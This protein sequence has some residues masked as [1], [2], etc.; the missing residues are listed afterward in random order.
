MMLQDFPEPLCRSARQNATVLVIYWT[1]GTC[2]FHWLKYSG[3][4][5]PL[6]VSR[7]CVAPFS[8]CGCL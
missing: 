3:R 1:R 2:V 6:A 7:G 4:L 5:N 8:F